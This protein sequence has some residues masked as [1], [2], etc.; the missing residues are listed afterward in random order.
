[1]RRNMR[2][3][4]GIFHARVENTTDVFCGGNAW[5]GPTT[6]GV[7]FRLFDHPIPRTIETWP[8]TSDALC[9][10]CRHPF[11]TVPVA[12]PMQ[13]EHGT[14]NMRGIYCGWGCA[15]RF[16]LDQDYFNVASVL[17]N[18]KQTAAQFGVTDAIVAAPPFTALR[19]FGGHLNI[20]EFRGKQVRV[21]AVDYP[22]YNFS[23]GFVEERVVG[24]VGGLLRRPESVA[25]TR[26]LVSNTENESMYKAFLAEDRPRRPPKK[27]QVTLGS[28][29]SFLKKK[30]KK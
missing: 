8:A 3:N 11:T 4:T 21:S 14:W 5:A 10:H 6:T 28:M 13:F 20:E 16:V 30:R 12:V 22:F 27:R 26:T 15:K 25:P 24:R 1:M 18:M 17:F 29:G 9:W 7:G 2:S 19:A 23:M